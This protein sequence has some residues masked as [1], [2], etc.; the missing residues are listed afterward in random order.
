MKLPNKRKSKQATEARKILDDENLGQL[1]VRLDKSLRLQFALS[2]KFQKTSMNQVLNGAIKKYVEKN[3][4]SVLQGAGN[5]D[6]QAIRR[7]DY[8]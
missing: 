2:A 4:N 1:I 6:E 7:G 5:L 3:Y 8:D